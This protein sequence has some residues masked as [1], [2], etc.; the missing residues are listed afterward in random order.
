MMSSSAKATSLLTLP[1]PEMP[2]LGG[3]LAG[4]KTLAPAGQDGPLG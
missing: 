4:Q 3:L 2:G 1:V